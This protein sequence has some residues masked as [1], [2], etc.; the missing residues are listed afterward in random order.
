MPKWAHGRDPLRLSQPGSYQNLV[1]ALLQFFGW[2]Q[3]WQSVL[4]G[5]DNAEASRHVF[6]GNG[7]GVE[8]NC[9][10]EL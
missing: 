5:I 1:E 3:H 9:L 10:V 4:I 2:W 8:K 6:D 7:I